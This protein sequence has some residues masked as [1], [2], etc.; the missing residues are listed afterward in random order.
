MIQ[1]PETAWTE[2]VVVANAANADSEIR[3]KIERGTMVERELER[4]RVRHEATLK[5]QQELDADQTPTLEMSTLATYQSNPAAAPA[6]LIEGVLKDN[7][8]CIMLGPSGSGKSTLA[9]QMVHS[10]KASTD[11]LGQ[12]TMSLTG[13]VGIMSYDM[14]ASMVMDWMAGFPNVDPATISV[15]NAYK[16]GNP[17]GVPAMRAQIAAA[18]R[19]MNTEVVIVDSFSASFFGHDQNDAA[20]TMAHYR[21]LKLFALTEVGA[22]VL[23]VITHSTEGS[24]H[25]ARGSSVHHDVADSIVSVESDKTG[26]RTVRMVKYRA[27]RGQLQMDP[28]IVTAPDPVTHLVGLDLG[29]MSFA[30]M[31]LPASL[32]AAAFPAL[33]EPNESPDTSPDA[34]SESEDDL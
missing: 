21:D 14:D 24:P 13:G 16:R 9:L 7:G 22:R 29:A 12:Q 8:L 2:W 23:I 18:W 34:D 26:S 33:P 28:V 4:L 30:G 17:L 25:K 15:V 5:F 32:G 11:W 6:D 20:A 10:L 19:S 3:K 31:H 1:F 27:A